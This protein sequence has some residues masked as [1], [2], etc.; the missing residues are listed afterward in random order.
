MKITLRD[1]PGTCDKMLII[2]AEGL[3]S[4][5]MIIKDWHKQIIDHL[6]KLKLKES[7]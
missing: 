5:D 3:A 7:K 4:E 2:K 1:V 6:S